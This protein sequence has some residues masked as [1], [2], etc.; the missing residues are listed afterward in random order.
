MASPSLST[1]GIL[2]TPV[3]V[4]HP[5][6]SI[7]HIQMHEG[8]IIKPPQPLS[9]NNWIMWCEH[10]LRL[11]AIYEIDQYLLGKVTCPDTVSNKTV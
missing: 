10:M 5:E 11:A 8:S 6:L 4:Q 9:E 1:L 2:S 7:Q 3:S